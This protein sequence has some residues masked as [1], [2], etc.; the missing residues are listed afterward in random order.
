[1]SELAQPGHADQAPIIR[2]TQVTRKPDLLGET[3]VWD[4]DQD[5]LWWIDG[6]AGQVRRMT[7][8]DKD[9]QPESFGF[10]G[11][12]GSIALAEDGCVLVALERSVVLFRPGEPIQLVVLDLGPPASPLRLNDGTTDRQGR[13]IV[14]DISTDRQPTGQVHQIHPDG[15]H[16]I[17]HEGIL[18]G[19]GVCFSP[20]GETLYFSDTAARRVYAC[21]YDIRTGEAKAPRVHIDTSALNSGTDGATVDRDGNLWATLIHTARIGCFDPQGRLIDSF[22][23][24]T[25]LPS[26][27]AFGGPSMDVLYVTSIKDSG[28]GRAVSHHPLGGHLFAVERLGAKG[29]PDKRFGQTGDT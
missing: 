22:A 14:A 13:F 26:C 8:T 18:V 19:N 11:H 23:A 24:P 6:A 2:F 10:R 15:R 20:E 16:R 28:T 7:V 3:P 29:L 21:D 4:A 25:D 12:V 5:C 17:L 9:P 27:V 1:M